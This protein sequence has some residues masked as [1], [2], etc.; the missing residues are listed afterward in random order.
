MHKNKTKKTKLFIFILKLITFKDP[1]IKEPF[2]E[3]FEKY[4]SLNEDEYKKFLGYYKKNWLNNPYI[5]Y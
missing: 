2:F 5:N 4:F 1:D 3:N